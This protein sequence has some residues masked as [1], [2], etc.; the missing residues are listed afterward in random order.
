MVVVKVKT[1]SDKVEVPALA[2]VGSACFDLRAAH[3][4]IVKPG[5]LSSIG[6]GLQME[7]P[8]GY[9]LDLIS[10]S[11]FAFK[12]QTRLVNCYA[13]IDSDFRDEIKV[14][15]LMDPNSADQQQQLEIKAGDRIAQGR[16][17]PVLKV[18]FDVVDELST[19]ERKGGFGST[20]VR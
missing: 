5:E 15:L 2:T 4:A 1:L 17:V 12:H 8:D 9:S 13:I 11:G 16:I 18:Q 19:T 20:G 10:R 7:I 3:D 6:T 14:G